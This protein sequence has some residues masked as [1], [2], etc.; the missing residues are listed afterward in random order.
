M[1][2]RI[3]WLQGCG[4]ALVTPF[5]TDGSIDDDCFKSLVERQ[6]KNGVKILI[7]CG[8]TGEA[9]TMSDDE[10]IH[11][12]KMTVEVAHKLKAKVVAGTGGNNTAATIDFTRKA[13]ESGA[14]AALIVAPYYNKPTQ[15]GLFAHFAEIAKSVK[16]FPVMLYN[17]PGRTCSNISSDTTLKLAKAFENIVATKEASGNFSQIMEIIARRPKNFRVFSGDDATTLPLIA[18]GADGLVSV[19]SNELPK[20]TSA[21]VEKALSGA[22]TSARKI[23]YKILA[24]AEANFIEASPA[25]C[26]FVMKEMGLLEENLRLP[27]VP[28]TEPTQKKLREILKELKK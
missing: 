14:D 15:D 8:T 19:I 27:L 3:D 10:K 12:I 16:E 9:V 5:K 21:M 13:R 20:E 6:I 1:T 28:I 2:T 23:H 25:P 18:V 7:P 4:T 26:K 22:W 24:L 17:V 11:V